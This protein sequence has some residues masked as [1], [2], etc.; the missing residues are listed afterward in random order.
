MIEVLANI[1]RPNVVSK[2]TVPDYDKLEW[3]NTSI[4]TDIILFD[5]DRHSAELKKDLKFDK[6]LDP[7]TEKAIT[8]MVKNYWDCFVTTGAKRTILGYKFGIDTAGAKPINAGNLCTDI[9]SPRSYWS[10]FN[11]C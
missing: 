7:K 1:W 6:D 10:K 2:Y 9:T 8:D 5:K 4:R 3:P 11:N